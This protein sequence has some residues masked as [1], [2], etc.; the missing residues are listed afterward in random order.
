MKISSEPTHDIL[1]KATV[2]SE[3]DSCNAALVQSVTQKTLERWEGYDKI[4]TG[5]KSGARW[6]DFAH[7]AI[8]EDCDFLYLND[9]IVEELEKK[10]WYYVEDVTD[11]DTDQKPEQKIDVMLMKFYGNGNIQFVGYGKHTSEEFF[12]E[13]INLYNLL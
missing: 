7:L 6:D 11:E 3:W 4:A 12:T 5:L 9:E 8:Y 13:R 2:C 10:N 1:I